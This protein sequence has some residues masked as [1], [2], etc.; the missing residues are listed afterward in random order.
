MKAKPTIK[1]IAKLSNTSIGTVDRV[2]HNRGDVSQINRENIEQIMKEL[3][4]VPNTF[5]RSLALNKNF[6]IAVLLPKSKKGEY[7]NYYLM[8]IKKSI[9]DFK[10]LGI[11][12]NLYFYDLDK[13]KT[14]NKSS[15]QVFKDENDAVL[16]FT[17]LTYET[18][19]FLKKCKE[20]KMHFAL[21]GSHEKDNDAIINIGQDPYQ[22]GRLAAEL[23][24]YGNKKGENYLVLNILKLGN[25]NLRVINRIKGF[26]SFF[27]ESGKAIN[28]EVFTIT[29]EDDNL[30]DKLKNKI[31]SNPKLN[32]IFI[33]NSKT[34]MVKDALL[35]KND[36]Q[37]VGYDTLKKNKELLNR[38][39]VDFLIHQQPTEQAYQGIEFL[40]RFL[41]MNETPRTNFIDIPLDIVSK[42]KL[43]YYK[44]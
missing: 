43:M 31:N 10:S 12:I 40:Y 14:F 35:D 29:Q 6:K 15:N 18:S 32:G 34:Y 30:V 36:I 23:L 41:V 8:G 11:I 20:K 28:I 4:Y 9:S 38:G 37:I 24:N 26:K 19:I 7:W 27:S 42:E 25:L 2:I 21:I 33:A 5:A 22:G 44:E 17:V 13:T 1:Q 3:D 39:I 16:L